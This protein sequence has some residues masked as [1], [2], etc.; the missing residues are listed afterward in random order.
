[1]REARGARAV[2]EVRWML[3]LAGLIVL[4]G[5]TAAQVAAP[6][7]VAAIP[8]P[9]AGPPPSLVGW[10]QVGRASWYGDPHHGRKTA[11]GEI[12]DRHG[13]TAAHR[14]L[15]LGT[16]ARVTNLDNGRS[17]EVRI[18][19]RGPF[20]DGRIVDLSEGAARRIGPLSAGIMRVRLTV[21]EAPEDESSSAAAR[22]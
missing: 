6:P 8:P 12:Y 20:V 9:P 1:M 13:L 19:D 3:A 4:S 10:Q 17:V 14:T 5:C 21:L 15:P 18:N 7:R 11:S 22:R 16:L 2:R